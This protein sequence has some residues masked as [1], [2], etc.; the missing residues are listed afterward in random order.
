M[1]PCE[2]KETIE[3]MK[4]D[5]IIFKTEQDKLIQS[6]SEYHDYMKAFVARAETVIVAFNN[7]Q[8]AGDVVSKTVFF[9]AKFFIATGAIL[10]VIYAVKE[11]IVRK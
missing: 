4:K 6:V 5:I 7:I 3:S 2:Q 9:M 1:I 8:N 10:G 11:W